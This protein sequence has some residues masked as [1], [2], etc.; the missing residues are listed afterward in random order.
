MP[1]PVPQYLA[2]LLMVQQGMLAGR[3]RFAWVRRRAAIF[4]WVGARH[5]DDKGH[6]E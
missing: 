3:R 4:S 2:T 5:P 1:V 6:D